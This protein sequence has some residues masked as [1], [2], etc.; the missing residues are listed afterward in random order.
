ME[1]LYFVL[2]TIAGYSID[3][4]LNIT[5]LKYFIKPGASIASVTLFEWAHNTIS[6]GA[7]VAFGISLVAIRY[8]D[9]L[10]SLIFI[11]IWTLFSVV[12]IYKVL[13][14]KSVKKILAFLAIDTL[15]DYGIGGI[16]SVPATSASLLTIVPTGPAS[17]H[18][19]SPLSL[20]LVTIL[21]GIIL[22][23]S[24]YAVVRVT[25][26]RVQFVEG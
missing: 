10:E 6:F 13:G 15:L 18:L 17:A 26:S 24:V 7:G 2:W 25:H 9:L 8:S 16:A 4:I 19:I 1:Y 5:I 23:I 20:R 11:T 21:I 3:L 22:V 12:L 14:I